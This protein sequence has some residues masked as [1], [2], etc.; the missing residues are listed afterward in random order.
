MSSGKLKTRQQA[1]PK[2]KW[3]IEAMIPDESTID[4]D[5]DKIK[6]SAEKY[7][8]KYRGHLGDDA[9]TLY[10]AFADKDK[11]MR[12]LEKIYVYAHMRRDEDNAESRYQAMTDKSMSV[13]SFVSAAFSF[14]TPELLS[15]KKKTLLGYIKENDKLKMYEFLILDVLRQ[16]EH[17]LSNKEEALLAQMGEVTGATNNIFTMLNNADITFEA[18]TDSKGK[19][20]EVTHGSYIKLMKSHDRTLRES[21]YNSMYDSYKKQINTISTT[22]NYNTKTDVVGARIRKYDSARGAALSGDNI[23]AA[24]YDNL[25]SVVNDNLPAMHRYTELRKNCCV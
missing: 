21:A 11:I 2:Y 24:V 6:K 19:S 17:V 13:I 15:I 1:D 16:K 5:L 14:F 20:H 25:V 18:A 12:K 9:Q 22:Y 23:P 3:N 7:T 4:K 10:N 8:A